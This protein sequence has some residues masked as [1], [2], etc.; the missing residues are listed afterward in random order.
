MKPLPHFLIQCLLVSGLITLTAFSSGC[1]PDSNANPAPNIL[2]IL[3]DDLGYN[4]IQ[5][6][7]GNTEVHTPTLDQLAKQGVLYSRHYAYSTCS[8]SRAA[9]LSGMNPARLGFTP[10]G[11]GIP[12][13]LIT[14]PELL[15]QH[16]YRTLHIGKWHVGDTVKQSLP[17][18]QG[19]DSWFDFSNQWLLRG[20]QKNG[21]PVPDAPT[22]HNPYLRNNSTTPQRHKG[23]LTDILTGHAKNQIEKLKN[24]S[25]WF[26]NLWY[27]APHEPVTPARRFAQRYPDTAKGKHLALIHQLDES[28]GSVLDTLEE[29]GQR[30]NTLIIFASDNGGTNKTLNNNAPFLG[31]KVSF[32]EGGVRTPLIISWPG[33][34]EEN[35]VHSQAVAI[36]DI[37]PSIAG[38]LDLPL[39]EKLDG[40]NFFDPPDKA[41]QSRQLFWERSH[42]SQ[43][44]YAVLDIKNDLRL[45]NIWPYAVDDRQRPLMI[46]DLK[47]N[48][49]GT[50]EQAAMLPAVSALQKA[51]EKWHEQAHSLQLDIQSLGT[52][53]FLSGSSLLRTPGFGGF[54]FA[55]GLQTPANFSQPF[56]VRQAQL[57]EV[58]A[59]P[60]NDRIHVRFGD[61]IASAPWP[62]GKNCTGL[63]ITGQFDRKL[64]H[65]KRQRD[66]IHFD[67]YINGEHSGSYRSTGKLEDETALSAPLEINNQWLASASPPRIFSKYLTENPPL[68]VRQVNG[69]LCGQ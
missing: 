61:H 16:G 57:W 65:R 6:Y 9:L 53:S 15:K 54:S 22:Y 68:T 18:H 52:S 12:S 8:P 55:A 59:S 4:D 62:A 58:S 40:F 36:Y 2:L 28:V 21:K 67:I 51:Y 23:H 45:Y 37:Y 32:M 64:N 30:E 10:N 20:R 60:G 26:I 47:S 46:N 35:T 25:P 29:T 5:A 41:T 42:L 38:L 17:E 1:Q 66:H 49:E 48:P 56:I 34:L 14:L 3:A 33:R 50:L 19:F 27:Y 13:E 24:Q 7:N 39:S 44:G 31:Q 69:Q 11:R 63:I 43:Y